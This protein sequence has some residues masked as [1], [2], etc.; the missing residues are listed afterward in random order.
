MMPFELKNVGGTYQQLLNKIFKQHIRRN[1]GAYIDDMLIKSIEQTDHI[2][3][4]QEAF[5]VL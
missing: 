5:D 2:R 4:I 3:D 1:M